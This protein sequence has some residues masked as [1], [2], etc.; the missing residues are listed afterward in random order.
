MLWADRVR[1]IPRTFVHTA[2]PRIS[3]RFCGEYD[4]VVFFFLSV[5][6]FTAEGSL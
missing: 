4:W 3:R 1:R 6:L 5:L 2:A